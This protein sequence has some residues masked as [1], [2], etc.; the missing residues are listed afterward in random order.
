MSLD[1]S[2]GKRQ[3]V[4]I[5]TTRLKPELKYLAEIAARS[6]RRSLSSFLELS[7]EHA[8]RGLYIEEPETLQ[9]RIDALLTSSGPD[10]EDGPLSAAKPDALHPSVWD[11]RTELWDDNESDRFMKLSR[12]HPYLLSTEER[13]IK[14]VIANTEHWRAILL[15]KPAQED[16]SFVRDNWDQI[17][18]IAEGESIP[19]EWKRTENTATQAKGRK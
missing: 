8:L 12:R 9:K 16:V 5:V 19:S 15:R 4:E 10:A 6:Q 13:A 18:R 3:R 2:S 7:V 1:K 11:C 17:K 14:S